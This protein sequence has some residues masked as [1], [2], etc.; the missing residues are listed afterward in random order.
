MSRIP[1]RRALPRLLALTVATAATAAVLVPAPAMAVDGGGTRAASQSPFV[2]AFEPTLVARA[3]LSADHLEPGPASGALASSGNGRTGPWPGQVI[4]GF[5]AS[6]DNGDGT[7]WAQPDNGFGTKANS[8]DFL[9]R[10]YLIRPS[11]QTAEGGDGSIA[12]E[13]FVSYNDR[14]GMLDFPIANEATAERLLTGAD[15]DIESVVLAK[16][17]TFW[18]G[19]EFGPFLCTSTRTAPSSR[20]RTR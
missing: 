5:S 12:V 17:G 15:F 1:R 8:A 18:V 20:S 6:I 14:N 9:L 19:E 16:D 3:T 4:P 11:W 10:N 2:Q 7:F 13:R